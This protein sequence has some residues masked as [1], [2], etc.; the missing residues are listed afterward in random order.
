MAETEADLR[1]LLA[2]PDTYRLLFMQGGAS[3]QFGLLP[4]NLL[5]PG[6]SADYLE[7][8]HW[9]RK[10]IAEARRHSPVNVI[11]SGADRDFTAVPAFEGSPQNPENNVR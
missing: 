3:A 9:A 1:A 4:L 8:G 5:H 10:A 2:I 7:S 6:Q 11:A